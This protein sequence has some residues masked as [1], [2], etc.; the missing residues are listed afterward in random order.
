MLGRK[1]GVGTLVK[2][3]YPRIIL[4]HCLNHRL[5]LAVGDA[6]KEVHGISHFQSFI[7]KLH[8]IYSA[9]PKNI[10]ELQQCSASLD[11]QMLKIG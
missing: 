5:E 1:A 6:V 7:S 3:K 10:R 11:E 4:W 2:L 9:S 8:S